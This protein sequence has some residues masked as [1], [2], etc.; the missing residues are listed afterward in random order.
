MAG[1]ATE[2]KGMTIGHVTA[3]VLFVV[4]IVWANVCYY[5]ERSTMTPEEREAYDEELMND[6]RI[7]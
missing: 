6:L 2:E 4:F 5:R 1:S 7:W 3:I